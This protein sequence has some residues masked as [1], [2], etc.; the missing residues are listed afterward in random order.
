MRYL[1]K[2]NGS[3]D[4]PWGIMFSTNF[5][6]NDGGI[7]TMSINGP[8][9]VY[10]GTTG[11]LTLNTASSRTGNTILNNGVLQLGST[12]AAIELAQLVWAIP[13]A[14]VAGV[15]V[16]LSRLLAAVIVFG[17][18]FRLWGLRLPEPI[19]PLAVVFAWGVIRPSVLAPF[20]VLLM[21]LFLDV[22][23]GG[24]LGLWPICLLMAV[25]AIAIALAGV[26]LSWRRIN[27]EYRARNETEQFVMV[28]FKKFN[29]IR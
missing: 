4:L 7:R 17:V 28:L 26:A 9:Q 13:I 6:W 23:W 20:G 10:G 8:G 1:F 11:T 25:V 29:V 15:A 3:Y 5:N 2:V 16:T 19:F 18:P 14:I 27:P 21:G 24:P 22:Y 12:P